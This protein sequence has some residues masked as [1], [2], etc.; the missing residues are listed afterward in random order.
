MKFIKE[1]RNSFEICQGTGKWQSKGNVGIGT[2]TPNLKLDVEDDIQIGTGT[3]G[4]VKDADNTTLVGTCVSDIRLKENIKLLPPMLDKVTALQP[5]TFRWKQDG[6]ATE[7][8]LIAQ[9]VQKTMPELVTEDDKGYL[10]VSY[11]TKLFMMMLQSIK[12]LKAENDAL[13]SRLSKL[14]GK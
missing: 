2:T 14:E 12:E 7:Y 6:N 10:R 5:V 13:K 4:C 8:G 9:E 11:D 1:R 3:T